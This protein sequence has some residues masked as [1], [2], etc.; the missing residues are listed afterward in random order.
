M[1]DGHHIAGIALL[2]IAP[3]AASCAG[4]GTL[5]SDA[6]EVVDVEA[7]LEWV[8]GASEDVPGIYTS[9]SIEGPAAAV[10]REVHYRFAEDGTFTGA[11]LLTQPVHQYTVLTGEWR[12]DGDQLYLS[13]DGEPARI[14]VAGDLLRMSGAEG[15][16]VLRRRSVP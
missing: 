11:A 3:I 1:L 2:C 10:L 14:E 4:T 8:P 5:S 12:V 13:E 7:S 16:V 9:T 6:R 15:V